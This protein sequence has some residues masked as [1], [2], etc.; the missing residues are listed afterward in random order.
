MPARRRRRSPG[1]SADSLAARRSRGW[2]PGSRAAGR[3]IGPL[4]H[5]RAARRRRRA[6]DVERPSWARHPPALSAVPTLARSATN[7]KHLFER[8]AAPGCFLS[9][10][11]GRSRPYVRSKACSTERMPL[12]APTSN[13]SRVAMST[14]TEFVSS[15]PVPDRARARRTVGRRP[16]LSVRSGA[17]NGSRRGAA[18]SDCGGSAWRRETGDSTEPARLGGSCSRGRDSTRRC[19]LACPLQRCGG[20][21]APPVP[22]IDGRRPPQRHVVVDRDA[23]RT[24]P[25]PARRGVGARATQR[26]DGPD[27]ARG[28][29]AA[30][31]VIAGRHRRCGVT[32]RLRAD[33]GR[34]TVY[35]YI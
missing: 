15:I 6:A 31:S 28:P 2:H 29:G 5:G 21:R 33:R 10:P 19:A 11:G 9:D 20:I 12:P 25:R 26:P 27:R 13:L 3:S 32:K 35:P 1:C 24:R 8:H 17:A 34:S 22:A 14:A 16:A 23:H 4:R 30:R 18:S 7:L